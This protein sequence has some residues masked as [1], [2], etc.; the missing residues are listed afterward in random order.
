MQ[1]LCSTPAQY[2]SISWRCSETSGLQQGPVLG[3]N[4][5]QRDSCCAVQCSGRIPAFNTAVQQQCGRRDGGGVFTSGKVFCEGFT[6]EQR[7]IQGV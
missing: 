1:L 6:K 3:R 2:Q 5:D 4:A 7:G